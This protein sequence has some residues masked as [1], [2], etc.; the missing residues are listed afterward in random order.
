MRGLR[1]A[2]RL[3]TAVRGG[4]QVCSGVEVALGFGLRTRVEG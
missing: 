1:D 2:E 3:Y 4:D